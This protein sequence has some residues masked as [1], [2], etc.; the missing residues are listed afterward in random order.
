MSEPGSG[1]DVVSMRTRADKKG[2]RY[3]LNGSKTVRALAHRYVLAANLHSEARLRS[4][5][6]PQPTHTRQWITNGDHAGTLIVCASHYWSR[7]GLTRAD[8]P[9]TRVLASH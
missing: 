7:A 5:R 2:D 3:V 6:V 9:S 4:Y 1:S 8:G